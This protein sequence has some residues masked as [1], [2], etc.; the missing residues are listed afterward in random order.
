MREPQ[1]WSVKL[2]FGWGVLVCRAWDP[3]WSCCLCQGHRSRAGGSQPSCMLY[4]SM[5]SMR[6]KELE[7]CRLMEWLS[8]EEAPS[9][10]TCS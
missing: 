8:R 1:D 5:S 6:S 4:C 10:S 9:C 2:C 3:Q 7:S